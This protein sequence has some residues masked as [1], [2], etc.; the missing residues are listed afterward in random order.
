M[1]ILLDLLVNDK[2]IKQ[3]NKSQVDNTKGKDVITARVTSMY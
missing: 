2:L 3:N 1:A